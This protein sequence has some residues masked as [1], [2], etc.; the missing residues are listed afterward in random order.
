M[1]TDRI[2]IHRHQEPTHSS[3]LRVQSVPLGHEQIQM[4]PGY[5]R[6]YS[7]WTKGR[8]TKNSWFVFQNAQDVFLFSTVPR[9]ALR[10]SQPPILW[11]PKKK[12]SLKPKWPVRGSNH[13]DPKLNINGV[14]HS[15]TPIRLHGVYS[16]HFTYI[17]IQW[18]IS[19]TQHNF[20]MLIFYYCTRPTCSD[21]YRIIFRP[22]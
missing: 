18:S 8:K 12:H 20:F 11:V 5:L 19:Q 6:R 2:L 1:G 10:P 13:L 9:Q 15:L 3:S 4:E 21:F 22:F 16:E 14:I 17:N 7:N